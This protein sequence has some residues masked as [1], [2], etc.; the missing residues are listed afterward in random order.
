M[1]CILANG[2]FR[3]GRTN[4]DGCFRTGR[5]NEDRCVRTDLTNEDRCVLSGR[6]NWN[7]ASASLDRPRRP[8]Q[9]TSLRNF[10][11]SPRCDLYT[12]T[13]SSAG[14]YGRSYQVHNLC[15]IIHDEVSV[16]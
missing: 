9:L 2:C 5:T 15:N 8:L 3:T 12:M 7:E 6:T 10:K 14:L 11:Q 4:E 16:G 1:I 13:F